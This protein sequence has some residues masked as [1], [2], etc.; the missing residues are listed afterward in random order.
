MRRMSSLIANPWYLD[1]RAARSTSRWL[2]GVLLLAACE[3]RSE[4]ASNGEFEPDVDCVDVP[5]VVEM[6]V[7]RTHSKAEV[8]SGCRMFG[9]DGCDQC[10]QPT[11]LG[12]ADDC[13]ILSAD[14]EH[15]GGGP[16]EADCE[17]CARCSTDEELA[18]WQFAKGSECDCSVPRDTLGFDPDVPCER[19]CYEVEVAALGCPHLVCRD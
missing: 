3:R 2:F 16:C 7:D 5:S 14:G 8:L 12:T 19:Y 13:L 6:W 9:P 4:S 15:L 17:P 11:L 18:L 1:S 10:C